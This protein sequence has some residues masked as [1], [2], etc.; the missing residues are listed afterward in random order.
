M[1]MTLMTFTIGNRENLDL[2]DLDFEL[3]YLN[4]DCTFISLVM[5][6]LLVMC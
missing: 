1:A 2:D 6:S 4:L 5:R 3:H